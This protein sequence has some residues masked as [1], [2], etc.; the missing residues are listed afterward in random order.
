[1]QSQDNI[2]VAGQQSRERLDAPFVVTPGVV[3]PAGAEYTYSRLRLYGQSANKRVVALQ[4]GDTVAV[5][6]DAVY[7]GHEYWWSW[8]TEI[9]R[10]DAPAPL[11]SFRQSTLQG[12]IPDRNLVQQSRPDHRPVLNPTGAEVR[13]VLDHLDGRRTQAELAALLQSRFPERYSD[14]AGALARVAQ[15]RRGFAE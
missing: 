1:M 12:Q 4:A 6:L 8:R 10:G 3:L 15:I 11:A 13:L 14:E 2:G 7:S 5:Q 9:R